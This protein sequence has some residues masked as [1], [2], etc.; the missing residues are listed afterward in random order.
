VINW[1]RSYWPRIVFGAAIVAVAAVAGVISYSHIYELSLALHQ[2]TMAAQLMPFGVD[3]LIMVGSVVLL[4]ATPDQ[5]WLGWVGV[6][7]GLAISLFAN[8]ESGLRYGPLAAIWAG[9][10]ALSFFL[11]TF[12]LERW[13]QGQAKAPS[14]APLETTE[15]APVTAPIGAP[16]SE[17][18]SEPEA[19]PRANQ[20]RRP[21]DLERRAKRVLARR[22]DMTGADLGRALAVSPR[23]GQKILKSLKATA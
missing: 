3:G 2:G 7:P 1:L 18:Q 19:N 20:A 10:P 17:P 6:V 8:I 4:Q 22:P 13:L 15:G 23:T 12:I 5:R 16:E 11:A 21:N 14:G 9:V